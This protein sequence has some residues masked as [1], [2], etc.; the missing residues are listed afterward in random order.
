[1]LYA[2]Y[3]TRAAGHL[4]FKGLCAAIHNPLKQN[5]QPERA[6]DSKRENALMD[7]SIS[8]LLSIGY[9]AATWSIHSSDL[10]SVCIIIFYIVHIVK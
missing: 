5:G 4:L 8:V 3:Q 1:V 10:L 9:N 6:R 2:L 7:F